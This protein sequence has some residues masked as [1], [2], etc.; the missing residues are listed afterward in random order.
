[1]RLPWSRPSVSWFAWLL[2]LVLFAVPPDLD[3]QSSL[4]SN[5]SAPEPPG[6]EKMD[7]WRDEQLALAR[8]VSLVSPFFGAGGDAEGYLYLVN[9]FAAPIEVA[10]LAYDDQGNQYPLDTTIVG[11]ASYRSLPLESLLG[12]LPVEPGTLEIQFEGSVSMIEAWTVMQAGNHVVEWRFFRVGQTVGRTLGSFWDAR[13]IRGDLRPVYYLS[14]ISQMPVSFTAEWG[15]GEEVTERL[16]HVLPAR[17]R[18]ILRPQQPGEKTRSGW[19][20]VEHDGEPGALVALG[21]LEGT[22]DA[23]AQASF[24]SQLPVYDGVGTGASTEFHAIRVPL[25]AVRRIRA[26]GEETSPSGERAVPVRS[27][28]ALHNASPFLSQLVTISLEDFETGA[29]LASVRRLLGPQEVQ[30]QDLGAMLR[31]SSLSPIDLGTVRLR[32]QGGTDDLKLWAVSVAPTGEVFDVEVFRREE[33]NLNG[34]YALPALEYNEVVDTLVNLGEETAHIR[35]QVYW[36]S[37][38]YSL[39]PIEILPGHSHQIDLD[40]VARLQVPD[41]LGR[42]LDPELHRGYFQWVTQRGSHE[43]L[44]RMEIRPRKGWDVFGF[45]Y[46]TCC[47]RVSVGDLIPGTAI[48]DF[49]VSGPFIASEYV[50]TCTEIM[51][52][53][54]AFITQLNYSSPLS[55]DGFNAIS[56]TDTSQIASFVGAGQE[57]IDD[58]FDGCI[59][60]QIQIFDDG[61]TFADPCRAEHHPDPNFEPAKG[62]QIQSANCSACYSCCE[63]EKSVGTCQCK[64]NEICKQGV[65]SACGTCK[66]SCFGNHFDTCTTQETSCSS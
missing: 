57:V 18:T 36:E 56:S 23:T 34:L 52:P 13:Q 50:Y 55:W 49:G 28:L 39:P 47:R 21:F 10:V 42:T 4:V 19:I 48:L 12:S 27:V 29:E 51:G 20:R 40:E 8:P 64:G 45:K 61:P 15:Q 26:L 6:S 63:K 58:P 41:I 7:A 14:N 46:N 53:Y 25:T 31:G 24:L 60:Q 2:P 65:V 66:Q 43:I 38:S 3:A 35:A 30:S 59:P 5:L 17:G 37:G 16:E 33:G 1:M 54:N 22:S 32:V 11:P 9:V 44:H 62:C